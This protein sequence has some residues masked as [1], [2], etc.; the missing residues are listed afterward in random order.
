MSVICTKHAV[1][2]GSDTF[3]RL[4]ISALLFPMGMSL[5]YIKVLSSISLGM[6]LLTGI[7]LKCTR[8]LPRPP[9]E[10]ISNRTEFTNEIENLIGICPQKRFYNL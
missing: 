5:T 1:V 6:L 8:G 9:P 7:R 4:F 3:R 2:C 10:P